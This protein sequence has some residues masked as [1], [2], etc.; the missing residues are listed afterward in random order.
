[1]REKAL[2]EA[3][4]KK[5]NHLPKIFPGAKTGYNAKM[6]IIELFEL[7]ACH[8]EKYDLETKN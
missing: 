3:E 2:R 5:P 6:K 7:S 1:M 8:C 4:N